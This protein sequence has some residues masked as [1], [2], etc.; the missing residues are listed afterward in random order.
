MKNEQICIENT[1]EKH[2]TSR[3]KI[4]EKRISLEVTIHIIE[5]KKLAYKENELFH[6]YKQKRKP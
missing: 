3:H 6:T 1:L 5:Q 4:L 2:K